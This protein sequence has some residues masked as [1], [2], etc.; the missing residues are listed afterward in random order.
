MSIKSPLY[1]VKQY[2]KYLVVSQTRYTIHS[3]FVFDLVNNVLRDKTFYDDFVALDEMKSNLFQ[4]TDIIETV[5]F[6]AGAGMKKYATKVGHLGR[7]VKQ[8]SQRKQQLGL[9]YRLTRYFKPD[10]MLEFGTAAGISASYLKKGHPQGHLITMEGCASLAAVAKEVIN[11]VGIDDVEVCV[12]NFDV[13][14]PKILTRCPK[15]DF[16]FIDGNHRKE[17]TLKYFNAC[18]PFATDNSVFVFDDIHWSKGMDEA[19]KAIKSDTRVSLTI[20]LFWF[21]LVFF[22]KGIEKQDFIIRY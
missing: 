15:L 8:R 5:D 4:R 16:V 13:I 21:G 12:G 6:G 11:E 22:R 3:P 18:F 9:L 7:M 10:Y 19:W 17:P 2:L 1:Q 14:L 20:D